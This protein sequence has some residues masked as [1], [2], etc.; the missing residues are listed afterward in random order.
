M[1]KLALALLLLSSTAYAADLPVKAPSA[2]VVAAYNPFYI[3]LEGGMGFTT[4]ESIIAQPGLAV[5]TTKQYPTAPTFGLVAGY[6]NNTSAIAWGGEIF[7]DYNLSRQDLNCVAGVCATSVRNSFSF[8]EDLLL[9]ITIG[10]LISASPSNIQPQNWK[11]PIN[12]PS[13]V[14]NNFQLLGSFGGAQRSV[15][16]CAAQSDPVTGAVAPGTNVCG[17]QWMGGLAAGLQAR[18]VVAGQWDV[19]AK[20]HHNFYNHSFTPEQS[21]P[22]FANTVAAK[23]EDTFK[24][25]FNYHLSPL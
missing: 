2:P 17:N 3:G 14:V 20:W 24:V 22:L 9:G 11:F 5:G 7:G 21:V 25:G 16:L 18:F 1:K 19:A 8:G 23:S 6:I 13:S 10:Q 4:T 15:S 12:V